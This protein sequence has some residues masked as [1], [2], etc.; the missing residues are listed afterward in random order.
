MNLIFNEQS[1]FVQYNRHTF[2]YNIK[3]T[4]YDF[5][6]FIIL[7]IN[8]RSIVPIFINMCIGINLYKIIWFN[9]IIGIADIE[10]LKKITN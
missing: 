1:F 3:S 2:L 5:N 7:I 8:N 4:N 10:K 9:I 6:N